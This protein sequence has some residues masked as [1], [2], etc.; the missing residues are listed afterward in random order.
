MRVVLGATMVEGRF[1]VCVASPG[2]PPHADLMKAAAVAADRVIS[3]VEFAFLLSSQPW[4]AITGT[5]GKTT[6][7][8]LV[9]HLLNTAGIPARSVGNY[10]PPAVE[11]AVEASRSEVLVAEVSSFQL[12]HIDTFHPSVAVLLNITPDHLD[13]HGSLSSYA[14]DKARVFEN[15]EAGDT[16]VIDVDD[17][18]SRPYA[19]LLEARG[20][21]VVRVSLLEHHASG[22]NAAGG[23]L[24]LET[25]GGPV[26]LVRTDELQI[27]G[28]HNV[29]NALAAA[30]AAHALGATP[31]ALRY[32]LSSFEP[33][34]H[35]LE[36]AGVVDG[37]AWYNDSKAT[38]PDAVFKALTAFPEQPLIVLLGGRNKGNDFGPLAAAVSARAKAAVALRRGAGGAC[39]GLPGS[40]CPCGRGGEPLGRLRGGPGA[41]GTGRRG[42]SVACMRVLRRVHV[43][44]APRE[45]LQGHRR[46]DVGERRLMARKPYAG[47]SV[48]RY[49]L[50]GSAVFLTIFGLV[51]IYSA[52]SISAF[53]KEG[54]ATALLCSTARLRAVGRRSRHRGRTVRL[55]APP[56]SSWDT[57]RGG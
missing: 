16:A 37:A 51:M 34:E 21:E 10:G 29:S 54:S 1:G 56:G 35:R 33:I 48:A 11:A 57:R 42:R 31:A 28:S 47:G 52:S 5:N 9:T 38:N 20:V 14:A 36:P 26:R 49:L 19:Q 30:A 45:G 6:T 43:L 12:A 18:G 22:A 25:R 27:R 50:L 55:S 2:I 39:P 46:R 17:P 53:V 41:C 24:V 13:W 23:V 3:E 8:A 15:L 4:I 32:G 7:T 40:G 44:R